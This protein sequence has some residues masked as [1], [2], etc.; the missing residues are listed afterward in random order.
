RDDRRN[1]ANQGGARGNLVLDQRE[2]VRSRAAFALAT[3][4][5]G[6]RVDVLGALRHD[7][8]RFSADDRLVTATNPDDSGSRT[9]GH[10]SPTLGVSV[11]AVRG[12]T[13]Y[14][15]YAHA[16][17]TPTTTELA[18][19]PGGAGGFNP[20]LEPQVTDSYELGSK[21]QAGPLRLGAAVYDA[22]IRGELIGFQVPEA[23]DRTFFRNAGRS[24]RRGVEASAALSPRPGV[25]ARAA[26][27]Y[28]DARFTD[29]V[30]GTGSGAA[31]L[32]GNCVPG[33]APHRWEGTLNVASLRGPF[34][35]VD[36]R[37]VSSIP[38][39]DDDRAGALRSPAYSLV[40]VRGGWEAVRV[41]GAR[42]TPSAGITNLFDARYNASVVVNAFGR[43]FYE[44]GPGRAVY[45]GIAV[46][47]G[48]R[49]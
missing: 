9:L 25:T 27:S 39:R 45:T 24:R 3:L 5:L 7:A 13:V 30:V 35:G 34:A 15:N 22:R 36:A 18:N 8:F 6:R 12:V 41:G 47:L 4:S 42:V 2:R 49:R 32:A 48:V 19:R 40:D 16:F 46:A 1:H 38:V 31:D 10:W 43:R 23:P 28:T 20:E 26:Y 17:E 14:A 33:I 44:P 11:T 37:R 21:A 29:Y